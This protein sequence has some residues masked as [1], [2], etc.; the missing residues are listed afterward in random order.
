MKI[1]VLSHDIFSALSLFSGGFAVLYLSISTLF[2]FVCVF[3][4]AYVFGRI[5]IV[6]HFR[7]KAASEG[8]KTV[9]SD[10]A[11]AGIHTTNN[12]IV[13]DSFILRASN[14]FISYSEYTSFETPL[15][16]AGY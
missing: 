13:N 11:A 15:I 1:Y 3:L 2:E 16:I 10:L 8:S 9:A 5:P 6:K 14:K 12:E 4:Y 7:K